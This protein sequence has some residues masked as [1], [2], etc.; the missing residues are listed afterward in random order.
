VAF[1]DAL[2]FIRA[3][4]LKSLNGYAAW[5]EQRTTHLGIP[6]NPE[7]VYRDVGWGGWQH[8]LGISPQGHIAWINLYGEEHLHY[9]YPHAYETPAPLDYGT[10]RVLA[11]ELARLSGY[12]TPGKR[13][14]P[15]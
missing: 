15:Q 4:G 5:T 9:D 2:A 11:S 8:W 3:L 10:D 6:C 1:D 13:E 7:E 12:N 14:A